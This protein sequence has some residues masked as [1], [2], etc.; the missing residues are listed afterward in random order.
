M[1]T[2]PRP[3]R[4]PPRL[5]AREIGPPTILAV[6]VAYAALWLVAQPANTPTV[7]YIGQWYG[8]ESVLL[9]SVALVLISTLPWVEMWFDGIDR[10]AVWH[11]RVARSDS[12]CC[13]PTCCCPQEPAA[14]DACS[15]SSACSGS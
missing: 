8:A 4:R 11:R 5:L 9:L 13:C 2:A 14:A 7:S 15:G 6:V 1:I 10:A 12:S 3:A